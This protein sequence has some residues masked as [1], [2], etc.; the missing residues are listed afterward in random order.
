MKLGLHYR[1]RLP[2]PLQNSITNFHLGFRG[3]KDQST[4]NSISNVI[5]RSWRMINAIP[6][7]ARSPALQT[8]QL[9]NKSR[10][11]KQPALAAIQHR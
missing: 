5:V 1:R 10:V 6:A 3:G 11:I 8:T 9:Q 2:R 4:G 7:T